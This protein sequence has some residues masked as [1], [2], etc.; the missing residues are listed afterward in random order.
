MNTD[1]PIWIVPASIPFDELKAKDLEEC[2]YWL[3][4]AMGAQDVEW[5]VGGSGGGA[6]DGGRD[7]EAKILVPADEGELAPQNW[8]F[9]CKGRART[10]EPEA[11]RNAAHIAHGY[12]YVDVVV[13]V[14]NARFSNPTIE[15]VKSWNVSHVKPKIKLWDRSHLERLIS[16]QPSVALRLFAES[17]SIFG[18]LEVMRSRF[19]NRVEYAPVKVLE[20]IWEHRHNLEIDEMA[21]FALIANEFAN[22]SIE[23]RS[24][25]TVAT[26]LELMSTLETALANVPYLVF[27]VMR[28]GINQH[29][30]FRSLTYLI[31]LALQKVRLEK[32]ARSIEIFLTERVSK[33]LP[34][35]CV[36]LI[37]GPILNNLKEELTEVCVSDCSR[38]HMLHSCDKTSDGELVDKYWNRFEAAPLQKVDERVFWLESN[39]APCKVGFRVNEQLRCPLISLD[40]SATNL[41]E[42]LGIA[43]HI[44][45]ARLTQVREK[46]YQKKDVEAPKI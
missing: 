9:E 25:G 41:R 34:D 37:L 27:R 19:W 44:F 6:A 5:R 31:L 45:S 1:E 15:W 36:E 29:P 13:V 22:R 26:T 11:V 42:T 38:V 8:W 39:D 7:L 28:A 3:L 33:V 21:R 24:W 46:R 18:R 20:D 23:V 14:T 16:R 35:R 30:I 4:D 40:T 12:S 2:V 32:V 10:V 43:K 17:L